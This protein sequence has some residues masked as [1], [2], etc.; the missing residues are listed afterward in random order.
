MNTNRLRL[1]AEDLHSATGHN[2]YAKA[3]SQAA[4]MIEMLRSNI[5]AIEDEKNTYMDYVGDALGQDHD[6][7][8]LWDAA[9]RVLSER[10]SLR[11]ELE[12]E[13]MRLVA[14]S[15]IA[16]ANTPE[17]A[18]SARDMH[19]DYQSPYC[20]DVARAI[21][22]EIALRAELAECIAALEKIAN[23]ISAMK[24]ALPVGA[25][26]NGAMATTLSND[27]SYL[28]EIAKAALAARKGEDA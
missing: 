11:A 12:T 8:T 7:E 6:G 5:A 2:P 25:T 19:P 23:P 18:A 3:L 26:L 16:L 22:R 20:D 15:V 1:L 4:D 17:S 27:P 21:D 24:R 10:D 14:C 13:R 28:K 9:Q